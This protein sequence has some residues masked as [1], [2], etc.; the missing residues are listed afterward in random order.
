MQLGFQKH[1]ATTVRGAEKE[2]ASAPRTILPRLEAS[3]LVCTENHRKKT[4]LAQST[5]EKKVSTTLCMMPNITSQSVV[6]RIAIP[7]EV[8]PSAN[9]SAVLCIA[10]SL[11]VLRPVT[12]SVLRIAIPLA[13]LRPLT[14]SVLRI[15]IPGAVLHPGTALVLRTASTSSPS[16]VRHTATSRVE[17]AMEVSV[18]HTA[19]S[20]A[21]LSPGMTIPKILQTST[22]SVRPDL[23]WISSC[24]APVV[25]ALFVSSR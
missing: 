18:L 22:T 9:S 2:R 17:R 3:T 20:S 4:I 16:A 24:S 6:I 10:N 25:P 13:V 7:L 8:H 5:C 19:T 12:A 23:P 1:G 21:V 14:A 11:A 15:A